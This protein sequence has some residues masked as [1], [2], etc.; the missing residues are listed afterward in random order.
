MPSVKRTSIVD[1]ERNPR[2]ANQALER[3]GLIATVR[4][5]VPKIAPGALRVH[6]LP[7]PS[8]LP[9]PE[10]ALHEAGSPSPDRDLANPWPPNQETSS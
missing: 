2:N 8:S 7:L 6:T 5:N 4:D 9:R 3:A 10:D 1:F